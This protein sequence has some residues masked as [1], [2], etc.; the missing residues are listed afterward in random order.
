MSSGRP[1]RSGRCR[2]SR[3]SSRRCR[4]CPPCHSGRHPSW[5]RADERP[6]YRA[7]SGQRQPAVRGADRAAPVARSLRR[8]AVLP[9][10][11]GR[12]HGRPDPSRPA[13]PDALGVQPGRQPGRG[14]ADVPRP[15]AGDE[16]RIAGADPAHQR[17][18][19]PRAERRVRRARG[20]HHLHNFHSGPDSDG[21]PCDPKQQRFFFRG[22]YYDYYHNLRFAGGAHQPPNGNIQ[23]ALGFLWYHDHRVDHTAENTYKGLVGPCIIFNQF[24]TGDENTGFRLPSF[25][26]FDIPLVFADKLIRSRTRA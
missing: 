19:A 13:P 24:D 12:E 20:L 17:A 16:V 25:P 1:R 15:G 26:N 5:A 6:Q 4:C 22:Q 10:P 21:G 14:S 7:E 18:A 9:H 2:H 8:E 23:E 3:R 11:H